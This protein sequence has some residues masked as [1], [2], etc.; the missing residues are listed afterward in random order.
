MRIVVTGG[1][2]FVG[3]HLVQALVA[4][5]H[6][7]RVLDTLSEQVHGSAAAVPTQLAGAELVRG[8]IRDPTRLARV[9]T[10][11][12]AVVHLAA[13]TGVGQS[14]YDVERYVDVNDRGTAGLLQTLLGMRRPVRIVLASSRAVY[15]EGLYRCPCCGEVAPS[16]REPAALRDAAW[17]PVCPRCGGVIAAIATHEDAPLQPGSVYAATKAAQERLV[18]I[19]GGAYGMPTTILRYFNVY[20]PGQSLSNPYT[21]ILS[22]FYARARN[23]KAIDVY[24]DGRE[25]R[26]FVYID[27]VVAATRQALALSAEEGQTQVINVGTGAPVAIGDLARTLLD[28]GGWDV[29]VHVTGAFRVGDVRHAFADTTRMR[30]LLPG[31]SITPLADGLRRWLR[32]AETSGVHDATE[33]AMSQLM[34]KGLYRVGREP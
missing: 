27:D 16:G 18:Q 31:V 24:E 13:E 33:V 26:D 11:V 10:G 14:M 25:S 23:G 7:V 9:L 1:A 32:W 3:R 20:G 12:D 2:G 29:P 15:G 6:D 5:G 21:G 17:E 28:L 30:R 34:D 19:V 4:A 8:D 22:T